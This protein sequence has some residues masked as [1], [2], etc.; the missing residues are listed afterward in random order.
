MTRDRIIRAINDATIEV[1]TSVA[2]RDFDNDIDNDMGQISQ[3]AASIRQLVQL[4]PEMMT[5]VF[6]TVESLEAQAEDIVG[7]DELGQVYLETLNCYLD[8]IQRWVS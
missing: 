8:R 5:D 7:D 1:M 6:M 2:E 4:V 3:W